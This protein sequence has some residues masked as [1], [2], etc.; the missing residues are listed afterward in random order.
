MSGETIV[1]CV[2]AYLIWNFLVGLIY[3]SDK[4]NAISGKWRVSEASLLGL[5]LLG[6]ALG[7]FAACK[8]YRHKTRKQPFAIMLISILILHVA[9]VGAAI[10]ILV[11]P[12]HLIGG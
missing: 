10:G 2:I 1:L 7:A 5:A 8:I 4:Q 11:P 9:G 3:R 12:M 6:G